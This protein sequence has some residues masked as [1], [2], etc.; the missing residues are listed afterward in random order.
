MPQLGGAVTPQ[1]LWV[2]IIYAKY[3][4]KYN[5]LQYIYIYRLYIYTLYNVYII[6]IHIIYIYI[7]YNVY[8]YI[9]ISSYNNITY[10]WVSISDT[11]QPVVHSLLW[12]PWPQ[13]ADGQDLRCARCMWHVVHKK[14]S[15]K[16]AWKTKMLRRWSCNTMLLY[17][18]IVGL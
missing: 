7:L 14:S 12:G 4:V 5:I 2:C 18:R 1:F 16:S 11:R 17:S 13:G 8:I 6:Y 3:N 9:H 10:N 15:V